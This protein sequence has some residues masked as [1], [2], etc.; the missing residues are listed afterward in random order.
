MHRGQEI[1]A[2]RYGP[3]TDRARAAS[4][5]CSPADKTIWYGLG[6]GMRSL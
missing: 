1:T 4:A 3:R 5:A 2:A 6:V